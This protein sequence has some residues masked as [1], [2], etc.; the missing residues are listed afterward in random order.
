MNKFF[1]ERDVL[2]SLHHGISESMFIRLHETIDNFIRD[3]C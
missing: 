2:L 3:K 1:M